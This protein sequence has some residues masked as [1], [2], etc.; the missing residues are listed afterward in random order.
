[1]S[2]R[3]CSIVCLLAGSVL[4]TAQEPQ[5]V[6]RGGVQTVPIYATVTD[7][8]GRLVPNLEREHF[9]IYDNGKLQ[10]LTLFKSDV[11]PITVVVM[12]DTSGSMTFTI[13]LLKDAAEQFV[14]RLLPEDRARLGSFSER[15]KLSPL[16]TSN[17]DDLIRLIHTEID[18]GNGTHLWDAI[19]YSMTALSKETGR[20]VVLVFTDG[21]DEKS[22]KT[23]FDA[24]L[25]RAQTEEY[26][27]YGI[28]LHNRIRNQ[29]FRPDRRLRELVESTGGGYFELLRTSDLNTTFTR[30]AEELHRQYILGFSPTVLDGLTHV[31]DVKVKVEG[32]TARSRKSYVA[33]KSGGS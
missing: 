27:I 21:Q 9:E 32:M 33:A 18:F 14:I 4:A 29:Q 17:R 16:F 5:S 31:L 2:P 30:V 22:V 10:P 6:F 8:T 11:Q 1:M 25:A 13:D 20:R 28:G 3:V 26:M 23:D 12:L 19:D 24:L 15:I 7:R